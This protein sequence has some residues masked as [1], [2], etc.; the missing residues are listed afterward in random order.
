MDIT[1]YIVYSG[2]TPDKLQMVV[3]VSNVEFATITGLDNA[4][5]YY[6]GVTAVNSRDEGRT[7]SVI[8]ATPLLIPTTPGEFDA[9]SSKDGI[10]L[11]WEDNPYTDL[12]GPV[13]YIILRGIGENSL[14]HLAAVTNTTSFLDDD[15]KK[16]TQYFY[17]L[18]SINL[19][20]EESPPTATLK[21]LMPDVPGRVGDLEAE[22]G[23]ARVVLAW[24]PPSNDGGSLVIGYLIYKGMSDSDMVLLEAVSSAGNFTDTDVENGLTYHYCVVAENMMG[25]GLPS[26]TISS[27]PEESVEPKP[28][29]GDE[30][31]GIP[32]FVWIVIV[33]IIVIGLLLLVLTRRRK[34]SD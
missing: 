28:P 33:L 20:W 10:L 19:N 9:N 12:T 4:V 8:E 25:Q 31:Q 30:S 2:K 32:F 7:S 16:G 13:T 27:T 17:R 22:A 29:N 3:E 1:S 34:Y 11:S 6:F 23:D 26:N 5:T 24:S 15:P 14:D 21:V 18:Y